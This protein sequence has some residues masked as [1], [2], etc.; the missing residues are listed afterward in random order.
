MELSVHIA[1]LHVDD[2]A[3]ELSKQTPACTTWQ[4]SLKESVGSVWVKLK[5]MLLAL[6][7]PEF[8]VGKALQD[9]LRA[10]KFSRG[11]QEF[12]RADRVGWTMTHAFYTAMGGFVYKLGP[13]AK[14]NAINYLA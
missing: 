10:R 6:I 5:W 9:F 4:Q 14:Q 3:S 13:M 2:T 7:M 1:G 8:L 12:V 11:M